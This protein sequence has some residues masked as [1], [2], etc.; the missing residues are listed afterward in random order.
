MFSAVTRLCC[1]VSRRSFRNASKFDA[2]ALQACA[3]A[4]IQSP[5]Q[6]SISSLT[7]LH[8]M[9]V[10]TPNST[11]GARR[12]ADAAENLL[13]DAVFVVLRIDLE[14]VAQQPF[15]VGVARLR[16]RLVQK[17][18]RFI[19]TIAAEKLAI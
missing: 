5:R 13:D 15:R 7:V 14:A 9:P 6:P 11:N 19:C 16:Q 17:R 8:S 18:C 3:F 1:S 10:S 2:I 4:S 12:R